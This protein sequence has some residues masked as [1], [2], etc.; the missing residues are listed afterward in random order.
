METGAPLRSSPVGGPRS[1]RCS[2]SAGLCPL[3]ARRGLCGLGLP[4]EDGQRSKVC[5]PQRMPLS[6]ESETRLW[7]PRQRPPPVSS[8]PTAQPAPGSLPLNP[9]DPPSSGLRARQPGPFCPPCTRPP[10]PHAPHQLGKPD[11]LRPTHP[12]LV[13]T[14]EA[15]F[16]VCTVKFCGTSGPLLLSLCCPRG[17]PLEDGVWWSCALFF[18]VLPPCLPSFGYQEWFQNCFST[19]FN[20]IGS[21]ILVLFQAEGCD[22]GPLGF[23]KGSHFRK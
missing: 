20:W 7:G 16:P 12:A 19:L 15:S 13:W 21:K 2:S 5:G 9:W 14:T 23:G 4:R 22:E 10:A 17:V 6:A 3:R 1:A 8:A 18:C 11:C